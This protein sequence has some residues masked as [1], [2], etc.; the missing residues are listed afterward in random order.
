MRKF[1][2]AIVIG[3]NGIDVPATIQRDACRRAKL[4][5]AGARASELEFEVA[6]RVE[7]LNASVKGI[8][9]VDVLAAINRDAFRNI[10]LTVTKAIASEREL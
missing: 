2:E 7:D 10:E 4:S 1:L 8:S 6:R 5:I 3:I 9:N